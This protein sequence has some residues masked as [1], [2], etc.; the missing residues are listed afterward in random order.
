MPIFAEPNFTGNG[1]DEAIAGVT[2]SVPVFTP[3][4]LFFIFCVTFIT[5]YKK[6]RETTGFADAP[7]W[8]TIAG[9]VTS[10]VALLMSLKQGLIQLEILIIPIVITLGFGV[11]LFSSRDR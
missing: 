4:F 9:V 11:W 8:G 6:Q 10:M 5:G 1:L 7:L 2:Q 3:M